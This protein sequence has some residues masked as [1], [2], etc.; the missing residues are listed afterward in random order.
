MGGG[1]GVERR[2]NVFGRAVGIRRGSY[3]CLER[4]STLNAMDMASDLRSL[5]EREAEEGSRARPR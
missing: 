4:V 2:S 3:A 1:H 5:G